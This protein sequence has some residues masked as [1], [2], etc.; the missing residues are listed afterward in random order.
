LSKKCKTPAILL[1]KCTTPAI[2]LKN[3]KKSRHFAE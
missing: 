1:K 2:L 3:C